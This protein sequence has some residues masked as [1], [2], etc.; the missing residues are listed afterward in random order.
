VH[1]LVLAT[2]N[3]KDFARFKGLTIENWSKR[4]VRS[5]SEPIS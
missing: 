3:D 2:T 5:K 1:G 4:R